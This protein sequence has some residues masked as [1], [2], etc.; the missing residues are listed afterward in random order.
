M[1]GKEGGECGVGS[2]KKENGKVEADVKVE[3]KGGKEG[4]E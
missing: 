2:V 3:E 4:M 1:I